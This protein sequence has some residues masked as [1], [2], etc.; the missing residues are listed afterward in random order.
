MPKFFSRSNRSRLPRRVLYLALLLIVLIAVGTVIS[1][2]LYNQDLGPV[3]A[4]QK[5]QLFTIP[6]GSTLNQIATSL[7]SDHLIRSS[8]AFQLYVHAKD[9]AND[10]QAG[11]YSLS[12]S[13][14]TPVIVGIL[15]QGKVT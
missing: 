13:Q 4:D 15:T 12:P 5:S 9:M 11:T 1:R 6:S 14:S 7:Q 2:H 8:W 3:S 10:L